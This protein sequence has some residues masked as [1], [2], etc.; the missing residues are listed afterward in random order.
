[1]NRWR[2]ARFGVEHD[3][4]SSRGPLSIAC[5]AAMVACCA[6]STARDALAQSPEAPRPTLAGPRLLGAGELAQDRR[7]EPLKTL[8]GYFPFTVPASADAWAERCEQTRRQILIAAG[9]WPLPGDLGSAPRPT[10]RATIHGRVERPAREGL[11]GYTVER[12]ILESY[13][14][15]FVTGSLFRPLP[16]AAKAGAET[17]DKPVRRPGVLCPHGHLADGRFSDC[18]G[19][20]VRRQIAAGAERFEVGGRHTEQARCVQLARMGC[21]VLNYDMLGYADSQQISFELAH[22]FAKQRPE[23]D[24]FASGDGPR[25]WGFF[26]AQA[27]LRAQSIFG[28]QTRNSLAALDWLC[29]LADVDPARIAMTGASGGGTQTM[30]LSAIDPRVAVSFPAVMVSTAMQGGCTCENASLLRV[31]TGNIEFAAL[32]APRPL[33]MTAANDWTKEIATRGLPEL[34]QL[35]TLLGAKDRVMAQA[36]V[37]FPHNYNYVSREV[38]YQ[39]FN[40]HLQLGFESP[41]LEED[42]EPLTKAELTVWDDAHRPPPSG[43]DHERSLLATITREADAQLEAITP[44]DAKSLAEFRRVVG[45]AVQG[46]V[47]RSLPPAEAIAWDMRG[48]DDRRDWMQFSG[49]L[50]NKPQGEELPVVFLHPYDWKHRVAIWLSGEGKAGLFTASGARARR[51]CDCS[52]PASRSWASMC[53]GRASSSEA[54][55]RSRKRGAWK[56]PAS[57][58][59]TPWAITTRYR[60]G[61]RMMCSLWC[62][63]AEITKPRSRNKFGWWPP[64]ARRLGPRRRWPWRATRSTGRRSTPPD[65]A[66]PSCDPFVI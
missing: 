19:E 41:V 6:S 13:P 9:L 8:D 31:H 56:I 53:S 17:A 39:F 24:G 36:L 15:H 11:P 60:H 28:L 14:G 55:D 38:M 16:T 44:R 47:G 26:S 4:R 12:V 7:L 46:I 35:Y 49:W 20:A 64:M 51:S 2:R 25:G 27:E 21:V 66:S 5:F 52:T 50:R 58:P 33:G 10:P 30:I 59:A 43:P 48:E 62:R 63:S 23:F 22:K 45:G 54:M 18:G 57:S 61:G 29:S 1:M 42:Y 40:R 65:F 3:F 34:E 32:V 37:Q